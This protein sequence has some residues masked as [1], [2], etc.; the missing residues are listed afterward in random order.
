MRSLILSALLFI[1]CATVATAKEEVVAGLS[2]NRIAI[3]A[4]F[5]GSEILIFGAV[6]REAPIPKDEPLDVIVT[7][8]GPSLPVMVRRKDRRLGIWINTDFVE[9]D[10]APTFYAVATTGPLQEIITNTEDQRY[11]VSINNAIRSAWINDIKTDAENFT[12]AL[13]RI[14]NNNGLYQ[15]LEDQIELTDETLFRTSVVLPSN[16]TEGVY[17]TRFLLL[18]DGKVISEN[19]SQIEVRKVG[20]ERWIYNLAHQNPLVYG[21]LSLFIAIVA[22][23]GASAIFR[24]FRR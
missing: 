17:E 1:T 7:V 10:S 4:N 19:S 13:I 20:L 24:Y 18:R 22:G 12:T 5:D 23:W 11:K 3:T 14:R 16:L 21:L 15:L 9:V 2:Q 8:S 6:K